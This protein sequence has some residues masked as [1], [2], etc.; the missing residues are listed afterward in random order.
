[1]PPALVTLVERLLARAPGDRPRA[2][3]VVQQLVAL[4]IATLRR[5]QSA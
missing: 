5:R 4:E 2:T 1:L 3:A